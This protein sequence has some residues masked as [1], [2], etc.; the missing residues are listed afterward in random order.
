MKNKLII[1]L[2]IISLPLFSSQ[3]LKPKYTGTGSDFGAYFGAGTLTLVGGSATAAASASKAVIIAAATNAKVAMIAAAYA[4]PYIAV[5]G[6]NIQRCLSYSHFFKLETPSVITGRKY[7]C[8][9]DIFHSRRV[10]L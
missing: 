2:S 6:A 8:L 10:L 1:L 4:H 3:E 7:F 9:W 5:G